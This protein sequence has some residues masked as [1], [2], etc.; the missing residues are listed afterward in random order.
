MDREDIIDE[1]NYLKK[2]TILLEKILNN[3]VVKDIEINQEINQEIRL[4]KKSNTPIMKK[5]TIC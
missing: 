4:V 5:R 1:L 2:K 3:K